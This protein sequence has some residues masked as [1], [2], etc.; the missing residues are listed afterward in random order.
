MKRAY[1]KK[2][3]NERRERQE[4]R[5]RKSPSCTIVVSQKVERERKHYIKTEHRIKKNKSTESIK[6]QTNRLND[7]K[8]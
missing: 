3:K 8:T 1:K 7:K 2:T 4:S 5:N 6:Y